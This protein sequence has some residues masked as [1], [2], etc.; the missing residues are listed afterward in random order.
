MILDITISDLQALS[1]NWK[2][3]IIFFFW[4]TLLCFWRWG[5]STDK[6]ARQRREERLIEIGNIDSIPVSRI[7]DVA[8]NVSI[9]YKDDI[10][11]NDMIFK[12]QDDCSKRLIC[13]LNSRRREGKSLT[14]TEAVIADTFGTTNELDVADLSLPFNIAAVLGREV[15][16]WK[17]ME[18]CLTFC[19]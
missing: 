8:A 15:T 10:W 11:Q 3:N 14:E 1:A 9:A 2:Y 6:L 12:D 19:L 13:E 7:S 16:P 17:S 18:M 4:K 5:R